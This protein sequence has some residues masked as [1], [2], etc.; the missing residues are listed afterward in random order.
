MRS[1]EARCDRVPIEDADGL[2]APQGRRGRK[3]RSAPR[4]TSIPAPG[5]HE[6][7]VALDLQARPGTGGDGA[8]GIG[9]SADLQV[10]PPARDLRPRGRPL[11]RRTEQARPPALASATPNI[12]R[13]VANAVVGK[14]PSPRAFMFD[15]PKTVPVAAP[16]VTHNQ[17]R[18]SNT[19]GAFGWPRSGRCGVCRPSANFAGRRRA[20]RRRGRE[21]S[22][23]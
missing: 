11:D 17:C 21:V 15:P 22:P 9:K 4:L 10:R 12:Q 3:R 7:V 2:A 23:R 6:A 16:R 19:F 1:A 18:Q 5:Q 20:A 8:Y 14:L 13:R